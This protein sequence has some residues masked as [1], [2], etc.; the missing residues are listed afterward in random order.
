MVELLTGATDD[1]G[2]VTLNGW[3]Q[4]IEARNKTADHVKH[5]VSRVKRII[6][7]CGF[8]FWRDMVKPGAETLARSFLEKLRKDG[9]VSTITIGD[10]VRDLKSFCRWL[11]TEGYA[12]GRALADMRGPTLDEAKADEDTRRPLSVEEMAVLL[13]W[14]ASDR[15]PFRYDLTGNERALLY[16]FAFESGIRPKQIRALTVERFD[17]EGTPPTVSSPAAAVKRRKRHNQTLKPALAQMLAQHFQNKLP[18]APAFRMPSEFNLADMLRA[19]MADARAAWIEAAKEGKP[20]EVRQRSD[21]LAEKNREGERVVFY[22]LRHGHGTALALAGV[23]Q[24]LIAASMHHTNIKTTER[25]IHAQ[26]QRAASAIASMPDL[27][28]PV[29]NAST[30]TD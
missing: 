11:Y 2:N 4:S 12:G 17:L 26:Q 16:R 20:R 6:E 15:A 30:G 23:S 28:Y 1:A 5:S 29:L 27:T 21:F 10:H 8:V 22:S 19:D 3:K 14:T 7:G 24:E 9:K 25:Y 18:T 13:A